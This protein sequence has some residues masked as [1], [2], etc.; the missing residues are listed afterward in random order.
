[1]LSATLGYGLSIVVS[2][3]DILLGYLVLSR[4][5]LG[6]YSAS[7]IFPKA[8]LVVVTP[9]MQML[10]PMMVGT[11]QT[12]SE[13]LMFLGKIGIALLLLAGAGAAIVWQLS[14]LVCRGAWGMPLCDK[15]LLDIMLLSV[16]PLVMLRLLVLLN[17]A[18]GRDW[19]PAWL[20]APTLAYLWVVAGAASGKAV[21]A[22]QF[23]LFA[24][25][26][27]TFYFAVNVIATRA[28]LFR[29]G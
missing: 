21:L 25:L 23:A 19:V 27:F 2:N 26:G 11:E 5:E 14:P 22:E 10:F 12:R 15:P 17:F 18:R 8:M 6:V 7:A 28:R 24:A 29:P 13:V 4:A 3:L 20:L 16:V 9:L 1:L